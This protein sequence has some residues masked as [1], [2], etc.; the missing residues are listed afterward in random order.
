MMKKLALAATALLAAGSAFADQPAFTYSTY[1][2]GAQVD[3]AGAPTWD[4]S[5]MKNWPAR[6]LD[7]PDTPTGAGS[8]EVAPLRFSVGLAFEHDSYSADGA[9]GQHH[10][11]SFLPG[12]KFGAAQAFHGGSELSGDI[13]YFSGKT[14]YSGAVAGSPGTNVSEDGLDHTALEADLQYKLPTGFYQTAVLLGLGYQ[15]RDEDGVQ[16]SGTYFRRDQRFF[17][18]LG[19]ERP[20]HIADAWTV[21]PRLAYHQIILGRQAQDLDVGGGTVHEHGYGGEV[22]MDISYRT[23]N[24]DLV[25]TPYARQWNIGASSVAGQAFEPKSR[26]REFGVTLSVR[27]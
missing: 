6:N 24:R 7:I 17:A 19:V 18:T 26:T 13:A 22:A 3:T 1:P 10:Y 14:N 23:G 16:T 5:P 21:T 20:F 27:F 4:K 11:D 12:V 25:V 8:G 9:S 15:M 2:A